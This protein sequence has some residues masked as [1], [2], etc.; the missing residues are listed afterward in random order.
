MLNIVQHHVHE[1]PWLQ[2]FVD[3]CEYFVIVVVLYFGLFIKY[4]GVCILC[5][6]FRPV[7]ESLV[8]RGAVLCEGEQGAEDFAF[9]FIADIRD[10]ADLYKI[11]V[12]EEIRDVGAVPCYSSAASD[13]YKRQ[14]S[15]DM[16]L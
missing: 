3:F 7:W 4:H 9:Q 16:L 11:A 14:S 13:V 15:P 10:A 6:Y 12:A 1:A 8:I 2:N 5:S